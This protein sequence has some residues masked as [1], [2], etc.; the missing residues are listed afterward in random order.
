MVYLEV[1]K[2]S[3]GL[4]AQQAALQCLEAHRGPNPRH[5]YCC[6]PDPLSLL[7]NQIR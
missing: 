2:Q 7:N 3:G 5:R 4:A 1:V 6:L